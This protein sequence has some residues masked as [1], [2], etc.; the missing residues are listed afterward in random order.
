M[1]ANQETISKIVER[2]DKDEEVLELLGQ[3][4]ESFQLYHAA[5]Y[6]LELQM[7]LYS[8][9]GMDGDIYRKSIAEMDAARTINHNAVIANVRILNRLAL[10]Y[11]L[12][13]FYQG[14]ISEDRPYRREL[15]D[16]ILEYVENVVRNRV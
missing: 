6:K 14:I 10:Q 13:P 4:L 8:H 9:G 7:K 11:D 3:I 2:C 15:A 12:Q 16:A 1:Q 5:I